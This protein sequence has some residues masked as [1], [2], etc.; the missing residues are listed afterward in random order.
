[1]A[2]AGLKLIRWSSAI[3]GA[4]LTTL[5]QRCWTFPTLSLRLFRTLNLTD[6]QIAF[7]FAHFSHFPERPVSRSFQTPKKTDFCKPLD[8]PKLKKTL[9]AHSNNTSGTPTLLRKCQKEYGAQ[10]DRQTD[11]QTGAMG[12]RLGP[13][14]G[15]SHLILLS[16]FSGG[17]FPIIKEHKLFGHASGLQESDF[18]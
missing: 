18:P 14:A 4:T 11:R 10:T 12:P 3:Q 2:K 9:Q 1:M 16:H 5:F 6:V 13:E 15:A 8:P 17:D 7:F